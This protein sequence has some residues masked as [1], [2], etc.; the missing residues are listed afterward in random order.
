MAVILLLVFVAG[1]AILP[2]G[3]FQRSRQDWQRA[4]REDGV[5][6][7][8]HVLAVRDVHPQKGTRPT[9]WMYLDFEYH[10]EHHAAP[11]QVSVM[12]RRAQVEATPLTPGQELAI[13]YLPHIPTEA[14]PDGFDCRSVGI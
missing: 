7:R 5:P 4:V 3:Y 13:H 12:V 6:A 8:A 2:M 14:V 11:M 10:A 1:L 9:G